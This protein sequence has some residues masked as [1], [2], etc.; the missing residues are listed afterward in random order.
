KS[1]YFCH[2]LEEELKKLLG[3]IVASQM[4]EDSP[5]ESWIGNSHVDFE[6]EVALRNE[7]LKRMFERLEQTDTEESYSNFSLWDFAGQKIYQISHQIFLVMKGI[8]IIVVDISKSLDDTIDYA[9][10]ESDKEE[11]VK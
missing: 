10:G 8:Y 2:M 3:Q 11:K 9:D 5:D 1:E 7:G 4:K 6:R